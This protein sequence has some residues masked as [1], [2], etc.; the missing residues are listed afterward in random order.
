M[1]ARDWKGHKDTKETFY[2]LEKGGRIL[3]VRVHLRPQEEGNILWYLS[4]GTK[5]GHW[6]KFILKLEEMEELG[7]LLLLLSKFC[8][9]KIY[10]DRESFNKI[11][12]L[13]QVWEMCRPQ[14]IQ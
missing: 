8:T 11:Q 7:L 1:S 5:T 9:E 3:K 4:I 10:M 13:K 6:A 14:K 2:E 12:S